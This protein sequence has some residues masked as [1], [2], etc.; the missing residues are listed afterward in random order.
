[1]FN[2]YAAGFVILQ[3]CSD[4]A[5]HWVKDNQLEKAIAA[6]TSVLALESLTYIIFLSEFRN[7]SLFICAKKQTKFYL[8]IREAF[9]LCDLSS[10][11]NK[12]LGLINNCLLRDKQGLPKKKTVHIINAEVILIRDVLYL[13]IYLFIYSVFEF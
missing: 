2:L 5:S 13:F 1:M 10:L 8:T 7:Q 3:S 9:P 6:W 11:S 12:F 4:L